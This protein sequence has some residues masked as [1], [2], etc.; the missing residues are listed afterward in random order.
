MQVRYK[1]VFK[2]LPEMPILCL[3]PFNRIRGWLYPVLCWSTRTS[4]IDTLRSYSWANQFSCFCNTLVSYIRGGTVL[5]SFLLANILLG[6]F[7]LKWSFR[8]IKNTWARMNMRH[9]CKHSDKQN[10]WLTFLSIKYLFS[11]FLRFR[12]Y[13]GIHWGRNGQFSILG[14]PTM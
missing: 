7:L 3:R 4:Q 13:D 12:T 10:F 6:Y 9:W 1:I 8:N 14:N 11:G 5:F 2:S